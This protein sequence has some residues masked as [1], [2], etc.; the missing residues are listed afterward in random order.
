MRGLVWFGLVVEFG[1]W[2]ICSFVSLGVGREAGVWF[3]VL[4]FFLVGCFRWSVL[5][6]VEWKILIYIYSCLKVGFKFF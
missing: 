3:F 1:F 2:G 6:R 4:G 5:F